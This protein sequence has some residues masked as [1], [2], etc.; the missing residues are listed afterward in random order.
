MK[1]LFSIVLLLLIVVGLVGCGAPTCAYSSPKRVKEE[2]TL[3]IV[4][5][6]SI[7]ADLVEQV[8][9]NHATVYSMVPIGTDPHEYEP[10]PEDIQAVTDADL[11]FYNGLN[12]ETGGNRWF[13]SL[14]EI[15]K[16]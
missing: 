5:T 1:K 9:G 13:A 14:M 7:L 8:V 3:L 11:I 4:A 2:G 10:L 15:T 16:K 6:N 12:L